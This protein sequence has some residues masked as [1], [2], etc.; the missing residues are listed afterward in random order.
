MKRCTFSHIHA[1]VILISQR[2]AERVS[3][4]AKMSFSDADRIKWKK[5]LV[6]NFMSSDES[7]EDDGQPVF[8]VKKLPWSSE[9]VSNFFERLDAA[10][11]SHKTEQ[12]SRQTKP[13]ISKGLLS[14]R[15]ATRGFPAWA[16]VDTLVQ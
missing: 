9:R 14:S 2:R 15:P 13:R 5:V 11:S 6:T 16:V 10:R 12:A 3:Q 8:I 7:G 4:F 1:H